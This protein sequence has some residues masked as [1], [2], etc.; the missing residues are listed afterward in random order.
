MIAGTGA[1]AAMAQEA[2]AAAAAPLAAEPAGGRHRG[3]AP[4]WPL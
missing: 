1:P 2:P 3:N 4:G